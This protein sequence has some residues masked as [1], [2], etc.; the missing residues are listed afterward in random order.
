MDNPRNSVSRRKFI[1]NGT[2]AAGVPLVAAGLAPASLANVKDAN[3]FLNLGWIGVGGR[4]SSLLNRALRSVST[5]TLK[6]TGICDIHEG[7]MNNAI[8]A[9]GAMKPAGFADYRKLLEQK[10]VDA[11]FVATPIHLHPEHGCA[12]MKADKHCYCEKP[13]GA[14]PEGVKMLYDCVKASKKKFQIGF[15]WRY[16]NGFLS[17]VDKVQSGELGKLS[18]VQGYRHVGGY[19][20]SGWYMD[21]NKSGDLIV[22]QAVHE[23][24]V[25]CWALKGHPLRAAGF[26]GINALEGRPAGRTMMDAYGVTYEFPENLR[27]QYSHIIYVAAGFGGLNMMVLGGRHKALSLEGTTQLYQSKGGKKVKIDTPPL[28]DA[29]EAAIQHFAKSIRED[30]EPLANVDAGRHATCMALLGRTAIHEKRAVEWKEV[31]L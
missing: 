31:A 20:E 19:P 27:L 29:T 7:R 18:F 22:E 15:Q 2:V 28:K 10:N 6:V 16:H 1:Q 14:S 11:V 23:M 26:G 25:F 13:M 5:S 24:N 30:K 21:R 17:F 8:K 4:G 9:C 12:V 3:E